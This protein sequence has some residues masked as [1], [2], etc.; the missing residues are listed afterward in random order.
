MN[1]NYTQRAKEK[2][3]D[4][5]DG[6]I[7]QIWDD[8]NSTP[9]DTDAEKWKK[10]L[11]AIAAEY[12][13]SSR[14]TLMRIFQRQ[15]VDDALL[16]DNP[17][18]GFSI[19]MSDGSA[20]IFTDISMEHAQNLTNAELGLYT[21]LMMERAEEQSDADPEADLALIQKAL[22]NF[23][24][25][26]TLLTRE[27]AFQL[28]HMLRFSL[29]EMEWFLLRVFQADAGFRYNISDDLIEAY[30]F[31]TDASAR[32]V[33]ELR[34]EYR[35]RY[36]CVQKVTC[37]EEEANWTRDTGVSL[38]GLIQYWPAE[39]RDEHFLEWMGTLASRLDLPSQTALRIYRTL[40]V[41]A[42][43]LA[44]SKAD[45]PNVD[46]IREK[47]GSFR[48]DFLGCIE[49]VA[50]TD[51]YTEQTKAAL[52]EKGEISFNRCKEVAGTLLVENLN[53]SLSDQT[54]RSKAWHVIDVLTN[55]KM[56]VSGGIN[57]SRTRVRDILTGE[58]QRIEKSDILYLLWFTANLC[59]FQGKTRLSANDI[60]N[61]FFDFLEAAEILL[62]YAGLPAFYPP[63]LM[64][65]SMMLSI[66]YAY[67]NPE[68]SDPAEVYE[69]IC[70]SVIES[71]KRRKK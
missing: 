16:Q 40:A 52:F 53:F 70:S 17:A 48:T 71:R 33:L 61:R 32:E 20:G 58:E 44:S 6:E 66:V 11:Q 54:D 63:H 24:G 8:I 13:F 15:A 62:D 41:F 51:G 47:Y 4:L 45:A 7:Y 3:L 23:P 68:A 29:E 60:Y 69:R 25:K 46:V 34:Q 19:N 49:Q 2:C 37:S 67:R 22:C 5:I 12:S 26:A 65:Q 64:E 30:G 56:T 39:S 59:W 31:L 38:P 36:D 42:Y 50:A 55:G 1:I 21:Q 10:K 9:M 27:E 28:G 14:F 57:A 43:N 35:I 18:Q